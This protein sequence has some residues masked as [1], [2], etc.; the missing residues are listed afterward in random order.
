MDWS[1][2]D[3]SESLSLK[4]LFADAMDVVEGA[5]FQRMVTAGLPGGIAAVL[6]VLAEDVNRRVHG[7]ISRNSLFIFS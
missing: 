1:S 5:D 7:G 3:A 4:R 2:V 6:D